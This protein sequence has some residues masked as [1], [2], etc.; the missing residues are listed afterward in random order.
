MEP[1]IGN[2]ESPRT[3]CNAKEEKDRNERKAGPFDR[4]RKQRCNDDD[5]SD[6]RNG[7]DEAFHSVLEESWELRC[8][9]DVTACARRPLCRRSSTGKHTANDSMRTANCGRLCRRGELPRSSGECSAGSKMPEC[10]M[11]ARASYSTKRS[12]CTSRRLVALRYACAW[13]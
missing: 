9:P 10:R 13:R 5:N 1:Y 6:E 7:S 8:T 3:E 11:H 12:R 4:A 2:S